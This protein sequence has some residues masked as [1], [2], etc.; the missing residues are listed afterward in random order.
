MSLSQA[1]ALSDRPLPPLS[2][3][4]I[5]VALTVATWELRHRTRKS[6]GCLTPHLLADIGLNPA[7]AETER[8]KRF[9]QA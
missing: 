8:A 3:M 1:F 7:S 4:V 2:R 5:T 6:L 9:W